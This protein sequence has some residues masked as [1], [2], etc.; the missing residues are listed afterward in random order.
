MADTWNYGSPFDTIDPIPDEWVWERLRLRR[1]DL[2]AATDFRVLPD[3]PWDVA[4]WH[5]YRQG[6]RD[7]PDNTTDP[8]R[9]VWPQPP[10]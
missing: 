1:N 8:R 10:A 6:L 3:V 4:P 5:A 7:L 9:A 2:L